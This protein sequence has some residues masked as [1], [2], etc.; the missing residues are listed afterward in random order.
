M[1]QKEE[2]RGYNHHSRAKTCEMKFHD[3]LLLW[4]GRWD[5]YCYRAQH[6]AVVGRQTQAGRRRNILLQIYTPIIS[7]S[8]QLQRSG[9]LDNNAAEDPKS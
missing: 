3:V 9:E 7:H 5:S 6:D 8:V 4:N 2:Q 1:Q